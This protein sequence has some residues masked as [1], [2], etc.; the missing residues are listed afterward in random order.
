MSGYP[1]MN[2][3]VAARPDLA[4]AGVAEVAFPGPLRDRLV[5]A[6]LSGAKTAGSCLL[7]EFE[8]EGSALPQAGDREIMLDSE[9]RPVAVVTVTRVVVLR[10]GEVDLA[11]AHA[12]GEGFRTVEE[13]REAHL[14]FWTSIELREVLG[15]PA[16]VP[17]DDTAIVVTWCEIAE[18]L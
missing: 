10:M 14:E 7:A 5:A 17:D 2:A 1:T 8:L 12:E 13:W 11:I 3:L 4:G 18:R 15:D 9:L 6:Y 16:F